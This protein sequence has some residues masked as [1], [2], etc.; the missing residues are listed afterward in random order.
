FGTEEEVNVVQITGTPGSSV[1][2]DRQE[3]FEDYLADYENFNIIAT[4]NGEF[5]RSVA[6][7]AMENIIQSMG[8]EIDAVY[9]HDDEC[10][11]GA[12]QALKAA[13]LN[14]GEDIAVVGVG[15]F[16]DACVCIQNGEMDG[17]VLCSPWFGPTV[18]DLVEQ[19]VAGEEIDS[20]IENPGYMIDASN[21]DEYIPDAF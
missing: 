9:G 18:M 2:A 3:G 16:K 4:Q 1:A 14:P 6:Q 11:I 21:V 19:L 20:Y 13:G 15:G 17:T 7:E 10:A 12:V 5:T 8:D